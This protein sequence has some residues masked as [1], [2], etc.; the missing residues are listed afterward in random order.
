MS[1]LVSSLL[2]EVERTN[3]LVTSWPRIDKLASLRG[4]HSLH[5]FNIEILNKM[6]D[7]VE[8]VKASELDEGTGGHTDG[9]VRKGA[10]VGKSDRICSTVM[11]APPHSSSAVHHHGEQDT[12][13]Y[14]V[15]GQGTLVFDGGRQHKD[16]SPGDFALIPAYTKHQE[17]NGSDQE[18]EWVIVRTGPKPITVN[19]DGWDEG[20]T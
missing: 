16:L 6:P 17:A 1:S 5:L 2:A 20:T 13:V 12:V 14:A 8:K 3:I 9:M 7:K 15:R 19:L 10:I 4:S 18:V 11:L